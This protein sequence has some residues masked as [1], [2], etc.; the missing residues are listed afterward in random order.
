MTT[1]PP[2]STIG[3]I[4]GGQLGRMLSMA[5]A[6]LGYRC[7][8]YAPEDHGPAADVSARWVQGD[9]GDA[10]AL[11]AFAKMVD[12]VTFEFENVD[13][14][15]LRHIADHAPL[16]P[17]I[18]AL[19]IGQDRVREKTFAAECGGRTADWA[20]VESRADL[21]R[22]VAEIGLPAIL[23]TSRFGYDGKG[24]ARIL[25]ATDVDGAWDA[26]AGAGMLILEKMVRFAHEFSLLIGRDQ[27]GNIS[28]W[29]APENVHKDGILATSHV[30]AAPQVLEQVPA[31]RALAR[32]IA[33]RLNYIGVF[34]IE[35]FA[36]ADGPVFN[37]MAPRV[38]NSGHWTIE[39]AIASQF[40]NHIRAVVGLP[41]AST[42][43]A[44][45]QV[46]MRNLI[47][48]D[49]DKWLEW[50]SDPLSHIHLYGKHE[51]RPGRKMGHI[52]RLSGF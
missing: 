46:E 36:S 3:I 31:A 51:A 1:L 2:G 40:E 37:E 5:A 43:L 52:T 9:Y 49:A 12:V 20:K 26:L 13:P 23:K 24:Q 22:A 7:F 18:E 10:Q 8:I 16:F 38:H 15:P 50:A 35:F 29:D 30:P 32:R 47:G 33:E 41:L 25:K 34:A 27:R 42:K 14:A 44:A 6:Q 39:G 45:S 19:E 4:G 28:F 21:D 17:P 48:A 11:A